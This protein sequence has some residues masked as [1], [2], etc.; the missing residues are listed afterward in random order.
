MNWII[1]VCMLV[2]VPMTL[3]SQ[4]NEGNKG[5]TVIKT[6]MD[7]FEKIDWNCIGWLNVVKGDG[8][9]L[10]IK[11]T[12]RNVKKVAV[13]LKDGVLTIRTHARPEECE[14]GVY[15]EITV[16]KELQ[17][18]TM[19]MHSDLSLEGKIGVETLKI[20]SNES[21]DIDLSNVTLNILDLSSVASGDVRISDLT[22][23]KVYLK[24]SGSGDVRISGGKIAFLRVDHSGGGDM[25]MDKL[26]CG[27]LECV[28]KGSGD[29]R[30]NDLLCN[31]FLFN[32]R[33]SGDVM[34]SGVVDSA[35]IE[36]KGSG[37]LNHSGLV[38]KN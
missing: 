6:D 28:D 37:H 34:L 11:G 19:E 18:L 16:P 14:L 9:S 22:C 3:Q 17:L 27:K 8:Y 29:L 15:V 10:S 21:E 35:T 31:S 36:W 32:G 1:G 20:S 38:I 12:E 30:M 13:D 23:D 33:G 24:L 4:E 5:E 7:P 2:L 26:V 25:S